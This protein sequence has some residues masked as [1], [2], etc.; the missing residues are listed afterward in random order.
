MNHSINLNIHY[1]M[2]D[3]LW[4]RINEVYASMRYWAEEEKGS[5]WKA[6]NIDLTASVEPGGIP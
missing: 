1:T 6:E 2:P 3:N 4:E 5:C